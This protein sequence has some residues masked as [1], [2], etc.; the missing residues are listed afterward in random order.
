MSKISIKTSLK[1]QGEIT[2]YDVLGIKTNNK[3]VY[4]E[5]NNKVTLIINND[6]IN[7]IRKD[8]DTMLEIE[9]INNK[10][11][12]GYYTL[13]DGNNKLELDIYTKKLI[14]KDTYVE[15]EYE[16]NDETRIYIVNF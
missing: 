5:D 14:I 2:N 3:I 7:L 13:L 16:F 4:Y 1:Y 11:V 15:I 6:S 8:I 10:K 9:F 12:I